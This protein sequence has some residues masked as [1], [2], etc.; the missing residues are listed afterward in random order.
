MSSEAASTK[1]RSPYI[2][3]MAAGI[4][5]IITFTAAAVV[6]FTFHP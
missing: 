2:G 6:W 5:L 1:E 3:W 4:F